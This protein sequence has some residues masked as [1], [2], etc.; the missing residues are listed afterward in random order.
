MIV[1]Q[2]KSSWRVSDVASPEVEVLNHPDSILLVAELL[3]L[4]LLEEEVGQER[5]RR[6]LEGQEEVPQLLAQLL[7]PLVLSP[8]AYS[9]R[10]LSGLHVDVVVLVALSALQVGGISSHQ[11]AVESPAPQLQAVVDHVRESLTAHQLLRENCWQHEAAFL[12]QPIA[13]LSCRSH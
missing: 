6:A 8:L 4:R 9:S 5:L 11:L 13:W 1:L 12:C 3:L 10:R 7:A 2:V